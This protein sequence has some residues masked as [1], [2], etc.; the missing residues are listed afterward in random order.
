MVK[1]WIVRQQDTKDCGVC[2][3]LS[4]IKYYGG[5]VPL[6]TLREDTY[7]DNQGTTAY[8]LVCALKKYGFETQG[9]KINN[10]I[11]QINLPAIAHVTIDNKITHFVVIYEIKKKY[12]TIMDPGR[13][14]LKLTYVEWDEIFGGK[15]IICSPI[16]KI[17]SIDKPNNIYSLF[18]SIFKI[19]KTLIIKIVFISLIL[20]IVSIVS[21]FY[22]KTAF[23][24]LNKLNN[25]F[26]LNVTIIIFAL[27]TITKIFTT[28][29]RNYYEIYL[30]KNIDTHLTIPF[31][32]HLYSIPLNNLKSRSV[33][34]IVERIDELNN[35]KELFS[36]IFIT[37]FLDLFLALSTLIILI[38]IDLKL[39]IIISIILVIYGIFGIFISPSIKKLAKESIEKETV[40]K[41]YLVE[42]ISG[43]QSIKNIN[44]TDYFIQSLFNKLISYFKHTFYLNQQINNQSLIKEVIS[45]VGLFLI[46]SFGVVLIRDNKLSI[47]DL[48]VF[49]NLVSF[50]ITPYKN[51]IDSLPKIEFIKASYHKINDFIAF[52]EE[53]METNQEFFSPGDLKI[54]NLSYSYNGLKPI[55]SKINLEIK[56]KEKVLIIGKSGYGK[57]TL[58]KL[59]MRLIKMDEGE[60]LLNQINLQDYSLHT[61]R[62]NICYISQD[63]V[64]FSDTLYNNI[65]LNNVVSIHEFDLITKLCKVNEIANNKPLRYNT[66]LLEQGSNLS[67]GEKQRVILAR[68]LIKKCPIIILDE[69]L[70]EVSDNMEREIIS[71]IIKQFNEHIIIYV[72]HH[73]I[74]DLFDRVIDLEKCYE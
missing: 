5:Y 9:I 35:I 28:Y 31:L 36:K 70:S 1:K 25:Y 61:I 18:K 51:V 63:E 69:V 60:I 43:I 45:E 37:I 38:N 21:S 54:K 15:I 53:N 27:I 48:M 71:N 67:G 47:I 24:S 26:T 19:E 17:I 8:N 7:T 58:C 22:L 6:E 4:I 62:N 64:L 30:S 20:T 23:N 52:K 49:S 41:S 46:L 2:A 14:M 65:V 12:I 44:Q 16:N 68:G 50:L 42:T 73:Q 66:F 32:K 55:L 72:S 3:L 33:G 59:I 29:I 34:D 40:Y 57:S 39:T 13:G 10:N 11:E 74:S 56:M